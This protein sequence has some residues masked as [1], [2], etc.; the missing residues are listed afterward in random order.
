MC[1]NDK[2]SK[3]YRQLLFEIVFNIWYL[4]FGQVNIGF[5]ESNNFMI[6]NPRKQNI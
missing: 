1:N 4:V 2:I 3:Y 5:F 6:W